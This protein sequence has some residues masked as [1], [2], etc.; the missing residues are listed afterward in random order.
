MTAKPEPTL[1]DVVAELQ[2]LRRALAPS[3]GTFS[4]EEAAAELGCSESRVYRLITAKKLVRAHKAGRHSRVTVGSV[5]AFQASGEHANEQPRAPAKPR[6]KPSSDDDA[7]AIR[8]I[9]VK[10]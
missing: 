4:I 7:E 8:S 6:T 1:A 10:R 5:R 9:R 2:A 3:E